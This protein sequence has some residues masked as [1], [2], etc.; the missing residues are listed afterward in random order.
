[1]RLLIVRHGATANNLQARYTGQADVPLSLLGER[2][3]GALAERL[4][5]ERFDVVVTSDLRR[6]RSTAEAVARHLDA[7]LLEDS[8]LRE[9][10]MGAW[11]GLTHAE[12][13]ERFPQECTA[14]EADPLRNAP[15]GGETLSDFAAR[16]ERALKG[17][18][19]RYPEG[20]VLWVTHGGLIGVLLC[21]LLGMSL[22]RRWQF[23]RDNAALNQL[24][25]GPDW[26]VV[27]TLNDTEHLRGLEDMGEHERAQV[28]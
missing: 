26:A 18:Y 20:R 22:N 6:A 5:G 10:A 3:A 8:A 4:K 17:C 27:T 12:A 19:E 25:I 16:I 11:E 23:R 15:P 2:Q 1:M 24:E 14:W 21:Q 7:P 9:I 28:L 13:L